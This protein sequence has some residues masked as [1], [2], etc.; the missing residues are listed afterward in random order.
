MK[1]KQ[2]NLLC[3]KYRKLL[4]SYAYKFTQDPDQIQDLIQETL[5]R[6]LKYMDEL[7][8]N[9]KVTSWLYV[10]M[11][12]IYINEYRNKKQQYHYS[13][14]LSNGVEYGYTEPSF[15]MNIEK[16][17]LLEQVKDALVQ[18][19]EEHAK[20]FQEYLNGYK[21]QELSAQ[22]QIPEGTVKS[23][24]FTIKKALQSTF[25]NAYHN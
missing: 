13:S 22:F 8:D 4:K 3:E 9:P 20:L 25:Q 17:L 24:I 11:K 12:N 18:F 5:L 16:H 23:R 15:Q 21:Y 10:I 14:H 6:A 1:T 19:P 2:L 7:V